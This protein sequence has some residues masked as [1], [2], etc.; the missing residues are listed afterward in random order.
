MSKI[1]RN[2]GYQTVYQ[3][4]NTC[5]PLVTSPY[6]ARVLGAEKQGIFSYTQSIVNYFTLFA[7]LGVVNYGTRTIAESKKEKSIISYTFWNIYL[8]QIITSI[9][10]LMLYAAYLVIVSPD[11]Q[12]I[13]FIQGLYLIGSFLDANWLFFGLEK[14]KITV[15]RNLVV[16]ILSVAAILLLVKNRDDLWIYT[17]IMAGSPVLSNIIIWR[18][19]PKEI[20]IHFS[21]YLNIGEIKQHIKPNLI[22][23]IPLLGMSVYHV[24]D[25]TMLGI[26][27]SYEQVGYY[28]N[29]DKVINIPIGVISGVGTVMLPRM[30]TLFSNNKI[31]DIK[32][33]FFTSIEGIIICASAMAFGISAISKEFTPIFFG[34]GFEPC[35]NLIIVLSPVLIIKGLSQTARMQFLIP[36][37]REKVFVHSVFLGAAVNL[38][39]NIA[40]IPSYGAL[41]AVLGTLLAELVSCVWQ[42]AKMNSQINV[43]QTLIK[44]I[45]YLV[46]GF[47]M[48]IVV[49]RSALLVPKG[50]TGL[51]IE[52]IIG[53]LVYSVLC[54]LFLKITNNE[55]LKII[56]RRK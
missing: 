35:I 13:C 54:F 18:F 52:I 41:G 9:V 15:T 20:D 7:M 36:S 19:I 16:R 51:A 37:K 3:I 27:S 8:F 49:R 1:K 43:F 34:N 33:Y 24:M 46:I 53:S 4:L 39:A 55:I 31:E 2:L 10:S 5:L 28:Y 44:S 6:L 17:L 38:V 47:V 45:S 48:Y 42:F 14:F 11:N 56:L 32:K 26:L 21:K 22:L 40:F 29:A 30:S 12:L 23:F 25:K 50:I